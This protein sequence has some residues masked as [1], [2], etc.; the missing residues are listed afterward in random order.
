[1]TAVVSGERAKAT[2]LTGVAGLLILGAAVV[3]MVVA[4]PS[5]GHPR[6]HPATVLTAS[7]APADLGRQLT[8]SSDSTMV[9]ACR[10]GPRAVSAWAEAYTPSMISESW[11]A[12]SS[13]RAARPPSAKPA[14]S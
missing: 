6:P 10:A 7:P 2:W 9:R 12:S 4:A 14:V 3:M 5:P 13:E 11:S 1:M 8:L